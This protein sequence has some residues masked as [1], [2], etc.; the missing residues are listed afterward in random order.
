MKVMS[1]A[2]SNPSGAF[3]SWR[4]YLP[5]RSP[6]NSLAWPSTAVHL[7]ESPFLLRVLP[8]IPD[9][10][11]FVVSGSVNVSVSSTERSESAG[12]SAVSKFLVILILETSSMI[13]SEPSSWTS[14]KPVVSWSVTVIS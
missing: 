14:A 2:V 13:L 9:W 3:S 4:V 10:I 8:A 11:V 1:S 5:S 7:V 12:L 6:T